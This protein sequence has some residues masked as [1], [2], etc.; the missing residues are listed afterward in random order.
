MLTAGSAKWSGL[1]HVAVSRDDAV[2]GTGSSDRRRRGQPTAR[3]LPLL[4]HAAALHRLLPLRGARGT[5]LTYV[6]GAATCLRCA[7]ALPGVVPGLT[8]PARTS[9]IRC[10]CP[11]SRALPRRWACRKRRSCTRSRRWRSRRSHWPCRSRRRGAPELFALLAM[12]RGISAWMSL[13]A[14]RHEP[15]RPGRCA[16]SGHRPRTGSTVR[17]S[18]PRATSLS[19]T[20]TRFTGRTSSR[21]TATCAASS[22]YMYPA[23]PLPRRGRKRRA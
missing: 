4:R 11:R 23:L 3:A 16:R 7:R 2:H 15:R 21:G 19:P 20:R 1:R 18:A 6:S 5:A 13:G 14:V 12:L 9:S 10:R 17:T 8:G 22:C